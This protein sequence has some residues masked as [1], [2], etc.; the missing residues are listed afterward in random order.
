MDINEER[1][2]HPENDPAYL[3]TDVLWRVVGRLVFREG[4]EELSQ[5]RVIHLHL[6]VFDSE[7]L[8]SPIRNRLGDPASDVLLARR[9]NHPVEEAHYS[10]DGYYDEDQNEHAFIISRKAGNL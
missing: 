4:C 2:H 3:G 6:E 9:K 5:R 1:L 7:V 8:G 10:E